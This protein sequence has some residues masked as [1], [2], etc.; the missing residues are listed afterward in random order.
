MSKW[1][2]PFLFRGSKALEE[3]RKA[4]ASDNDVMRAHRLLFHAHRNDAQAT[5]M[6]LQAHKIDFDLLMTAGE[7]AVRHN[8]PESLAIIVRD[9]KF[10]RQAIGEWLSLSVDRDHPFTTATLVQSAYSMET[11]DA[12]ARHYLTNPFGFKAA[13]V[14]V[15]RGVS[16]SVKTDVIKE[17]GYAMHLTVSPT[18][19]EDR[20]NKA[21]EVMIG[22]MQ[23][24]LKMISPF[25]RLH[26][27]IYGMP[28]GLSAF[29]PEYLA[30][31]VN[32]NG[33]FYKLSYQDE[34]NRYIQRFEDSDLSINSGVRLTVNSWSM[35]F[36][37]LKDAVR[38]QNLKR[39]L[40]G[41]PVQQIAQPDRYPSP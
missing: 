28:L 27:K 16:D 25:M 9:P 17:I 13:A 41:A 23:A 10:E 36:R 26:S 19:I 5:E 20:T 37:V 39:L 1:K 33:L 11:V 15:D 12:A 34:M 30:S 21:D 8:A 6:L 29:S 32:N 24:A 31:S 18:Q 4:A 35:P 40:S 3:E 22:R 38:L 14:L 7:M 2:P